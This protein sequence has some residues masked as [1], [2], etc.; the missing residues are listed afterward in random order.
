MKKI[1]VLIVFFFNLI[2]HLEKG[3]FTFSGPVTALAQYGGEYDDSGYY[4]IDGNV[5]ND[6]SDTQFGNLCVA[7]TMEYIGN[8]YNMGLDQYNI[9]AAWA[10]DNNFSFNSI[11]TGGVPSEYLESFIGS[12]FSYN[13]LSL[14]DDIIGAIDSGHPIMG[15]Y[16][17]VTMGHMVMLFGYDFETGNVNVLDP[18]TGHYNTMHSSEFSVLYEILP[19]E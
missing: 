16:S 18:A 13:I 6:G 5:P 4:I 11:V 8:Y 19:P 7:M 3:T 1:I 9:T 12:Q 14:T 15:A 10:N 2:P 17:G